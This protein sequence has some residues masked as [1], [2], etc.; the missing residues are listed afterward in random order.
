MGG[1]VP[2]QQLL[3]ADAK[4]TGAE[5]EITA[6]PFKGFLFQGGFGWLDTE[7]GKLI[8]GEFFAPPGGP[9]QT[10][11]AATTI[12]FNYEGNRLIAAPKFSGSAYVEYEMQLY[13]WGSL[14]PA[15]DFS[16]KSKV[17]L[18]PSGEDLISQESYWLYNGQL[19]YRTPNGNIALT[20]WVRNMLNKHYKIEVFD[21][22]NGFNTVTEIWSEPRTYRFT[23]SYRW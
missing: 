13:R 23:V 18:D 12:L 3:N 21:L 9:G 17:F 10:P 15:F 19:T 4:V 5:I 11:G 2:T 8:V 7:F 16:Y 1:S 20:G 14:I 22:T 6:R